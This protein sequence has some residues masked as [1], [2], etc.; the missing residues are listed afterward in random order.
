MK[1]FKTWIA[2][3]PLAAIPVTTHKNI[4]HGN[5][6]GRGNRGGKPIDKLDHVFQKHDVGYHHSKPNST[7]R[8]KHDASLVKATHAISKD[9]SNTL[10]IRL[11]AKVANI[12]FSTKL[13]LK[14]KK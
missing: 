4:F 9:K 12:A 6:G 1:S 8:R 5:Y 2:E 11:K 13:K 10:K 3:G 7:K 14:Q